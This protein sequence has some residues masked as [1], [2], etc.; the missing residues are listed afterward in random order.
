MPTSTH[1]D[2]SPQACFG[3]DN[4]VCL[5]VHVLRDFLLYKFCYLNNKSAG[6][7]Q[8]YDQTTIDAYFSTKSSSYI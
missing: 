6:Q 5:C 7:H 3:G 1:Y 4:V 8:L 2:W